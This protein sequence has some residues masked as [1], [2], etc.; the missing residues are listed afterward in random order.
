[1]NE[2]VGAFFANDD[3]HGEHWEGP[4]ETVAGAIDEIRAISG[5]G[6]VVFVGVGEE[7]DLDGVCSGL[8]DTVL[9]CIAER[10]SDLVGECADLWPDL[11]DEDS[12]ALDGLLKTAVA[13]FL[14]E[15]GYSPSFVTIGKVTRYE[16]E[17]KDHE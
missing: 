6:A 1:M 13:S 10:M 2:Y 7:I 5:E 11:S 12:A 16:P 4:F 14:R 3:G 9:D 15:R 8:D 17:A